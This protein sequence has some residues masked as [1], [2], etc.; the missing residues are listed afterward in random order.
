LRIERHSGHGGAD[1]VK[2]AVQQGVD[3]Y[4]FLMHE[5]GMTP[6]GTHVSSAK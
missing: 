4:A 2:Q 1:M 3:A 5:L 6:K